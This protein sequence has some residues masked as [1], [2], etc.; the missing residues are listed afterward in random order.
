M[1]RFWDARARE[2]AYYYINNTLDYWRPDDERF[3][4][5]AEETLSLFERELGVSATAS[6]VVL[7]LGCG[8][9]RMTRALA[10]RASAVIGLDVSGE[11][12]ARAQQLNVDLGNVTW[13]QGDGS[14]LRGVA[15]Q[16]VDL[17]LSFVVFQ[18][19]PDPAITLDYVREMGRVLR[20]GG[21]AAFQISN[22]PDPHIYRKTP[23][24]LRWRLLR[25]ARRTPRGH[26]DPAWLGSKIELGQLEAA[27][28]DGRMQ[29]E[30]VSGAGTQFCLVSL[31]RGTDA[32]APSSP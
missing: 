24:S 14:S 20:A 7:D 5:S 29:I 26:R 9:G 12:I 18:H 11:M 4:A 27:A 10:A 30:Q 15:D 3:W 28:R 17:V 23:G 19:I 16:S 1:R 22:H 2:N 25:L 8:V 6:D 32:Q 13:L 21:R 31:R